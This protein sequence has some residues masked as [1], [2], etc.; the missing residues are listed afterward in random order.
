[1]YKTFLIFPFQTE[2]FIGDDITNL[3]QTTEDWLESDPTAPIELPMEL[4]VQLLAE[5]EELAQV[6]FEQVPRH[7]SE[8]N[9][10]TRYSTAVFNTTKA[11]V[12]SLSIPRVE[13]EHI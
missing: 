13:E 3:S 9:F 10:W 4:I 8:E 12:L 7:V 2:L 1:M 11:H 5:D 6:R